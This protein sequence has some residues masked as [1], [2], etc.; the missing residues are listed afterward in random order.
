LSSVHLIKKPILGALPEDSTTYTGN[1]VPISRQ[2]SRSDRYRNNALQN[3]MQLILQQ[4]LFSAGFYE[5]FYFTPL[6]N[7]I[8]IKAPRIVKDEMRVLWSCEWVP[9]FADRGAVP[10][11]ADASLSKV[12]NHGEQHK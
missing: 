6:L 3:A 1:T 11:L 7:T 10:E 12:R 8:S 4:L 2:N 9:H 5:S